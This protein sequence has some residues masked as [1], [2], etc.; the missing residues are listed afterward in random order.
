MCAYDSGKSVFCPISFQ[1][2]LSF[3]DLFFEDHFV[4]VISQLKPFK[5]VDNIFE[6]CVNDINV[7]LNIVDGLKYT[8][9]LLFKKRDGQ[10]SVFHRWVLYVR[11]QSRYRKRKPYSV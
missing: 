7:V 1:E 5:T 2:V 10:R 8:K 11:I 9:K 6:R 3:K 4:Q